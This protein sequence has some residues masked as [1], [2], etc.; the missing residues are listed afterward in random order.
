MVI[1]CRS[2]KAAREALWRLGKVRERLGLRRHR[3]KTRVVELREGREGCDFLG[4][5]HR[6]VRSWRW[7]R[8]YLQRWPR[9]KAMAAIRGKIRGMVGGRQ[10][11][12][13]SLPEVI[14]ELNPVLRGW[15]DYFAAG[16]SWRQ[17]PALDSYGQER[18]LLFLS[19]KHGQRGRGW[20]ERW[21]PIDL[22]AAGLYP[23]SGTVR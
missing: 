18:L 6:L 10:H 5:H 2:E 11:W 12:W 1:L 9:G 22:R 3:T 8:Y 20:G 21:R 23:L 4:F 13:R 16:N 14:R 7:G 15:G 17:F 19:K